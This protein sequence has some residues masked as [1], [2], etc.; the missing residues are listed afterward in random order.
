MR[1]RHYLRDE[2]AKPPPDAVF[3]MMTEM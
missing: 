2:V 3:T 1:K